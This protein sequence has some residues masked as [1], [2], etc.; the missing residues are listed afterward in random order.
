MQID[1]DKAVVNVDGNIEPEQR[2]IQDLG[3]VDVPD[4]MWDEMGV[5]RGDSVM[6]KF[7]KE[8]DGVLIRRLED[9]LEF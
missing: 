2:Q 3:R 4:E 8:K 7:D 5:S 1:L 9:V 6:V